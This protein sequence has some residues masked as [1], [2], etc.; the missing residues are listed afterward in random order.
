MMESGEAAVAPYY[1]GNYFVMNVVLHN[2][3]HFLVDVI[4]LT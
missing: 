2:S 3:F 1:A 4:E